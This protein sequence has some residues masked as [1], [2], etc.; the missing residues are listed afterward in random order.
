MDNR[1]FLFYFTYQ[2]DLLSKAEW[3]VVVSAVIGGKDLHAMQGQRQVSVTY[4][5]RA[6]SSA[7]RSF[8]DSV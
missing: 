1:N 2:H 5:S 7:L 4:G 8:L 6:T 3:K